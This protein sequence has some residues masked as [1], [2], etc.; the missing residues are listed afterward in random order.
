[1]DEPC[2]LWRFVLV[3][4]VATSWKAAH[5]QDKRVCHCTENSLSST[6]KKFSSCTMSHS[7]GPQPNRLGVPPPEIEHVKDGDRS[8]PFALD[9]V[10]SDLMPAFLGN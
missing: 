7:F 5:P 4:R 3:P 10:E 1:M 9:G 8:R 2:R 6:M